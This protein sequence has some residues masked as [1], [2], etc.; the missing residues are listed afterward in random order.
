MGANRRRT[1]LSSGEFAVRLDSD[2]GEGGERDGERLKGLRV[3]HVG[4]EEKAEVAL[5]S[6]RMN[7]VKIW[8]DSAKSVKQH[9]LHTK[10]GKTHDGCPAQSQQLR[11]SSPNSK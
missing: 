8:R 3:R 1:G 7:R 9:H 2:L 11:A 4:R 10:R 5:T 6:R